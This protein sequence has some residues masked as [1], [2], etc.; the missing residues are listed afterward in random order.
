MRMKLAATAAFLAVCVLGPSRIEAQADLVVYTDSLQNQWEN[1]SWATTGSSTLA[2]T[3]ATSLSVTAKA[4]QAAYFHHSPLNASLFESIVFWVNGG[5]PGGQRLLIQALLSGKA[6]PGTNL[7]ALTPATWTEFRIPLASLGVSGATDFD[8]FWIQDRSGSAQ[9]AFLLDDIRL[10]PAS[11]TP[12]TDPSIVAITVDSR[13][14]RHPISPFIYGVAFAKAAQLRELNSPLNRSGGNSESRYNWQLNAHN[15][16]ADWYFESLADASSAPGAEA[17]DFV[18]DCSTAGAEAMLT[19]PMLGWAPKLGSNRARLSSYSIKKYGPQTGADSQWFPDAGNGVRA[20]DGK[21]ITWNDPADANMPVDAAFQKTWVE[22]LRSRWQPA[23]AGGI[24]WYCM[25]NEPSL[26]HSTHRD[27]HPAGLTMRDLRDRLFAY[28]EMVKSVDP[29]AAVLAPEEWGWS[30]YFYSGADQQ[31]GAANGWRTFPD[32]TANG[33]WD[34]LP[35]LLDQ[36]RTRAELTGQ[37]ILD[38]FTVHYYPQGGEYNGPVTESMQERRNR[39]TRSLWD[40]NY[41]DESWIN[42]KVMLIPRLRD[43]VAKYYP[44]TRIG[45]TEYNWGAEDHI[46]GATA[47][48]DLLGIFGRE[49]LD[50]ATR[51]TTPELGTPVFNAIKMYRNY[52]GT[53]STFGDVSLRTT[54]PNPDV[55]SA[56]AAERSSDGALTIM[57]IHK[58]LRAPAQTTVQVMHAGTPSS[59]QVWQLDRANSIKRL[60]DVPFADSRATLVLPAQS[61][62]LLVVP[63]AKAPMLF[64]DPEVEDSQFNLRLEGAAQRTFVIQQSTDLVHWA[65]V[66]TNAPG[67]PSLRLSFSTRSAN[68]QFLRAVSVP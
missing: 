38:V 58:S 61:I 13:S 48:A 25:D 16:G 37:R 56:F 51:W 39:S 44:G 43:W 59:G 52:D 17:D 65:P 66:A 24:R 8:G 29:G 31:A 22:H 64:C 2:H 45:L 41:V 46:N 47:Q 28:A 15:R 33:G 14:G 62:T 32:R 40:T 19:I 36:A 21:A 10:T 49:S 23:A 1:W 20:A 35:W 27:V 68:R 54:A 53:K 5:T 7:P 57:L 18:A 9:P 6:Q 63:V 42:A 12:P 60:A 67:N 34:Y 30:G 55:L 50:V 11:G 26:W 3:G 4:W